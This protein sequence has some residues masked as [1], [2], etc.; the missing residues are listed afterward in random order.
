MCR[1]DHT[2]SCDEAEGV[3]RIDVQSGE[4][5]SCMVHFVLPNGE[6]VS[7]SREGRPILRATQETGGLLRSNGSRPR[8]GGQGRGLTAVDRPYPLA[9]AW[10]R[11]LIHS[12]FPM[13][14]IAY[15]IHHQRVAFLPIQPCVVAQDSIRY[16][17]LISGSALSAETCSS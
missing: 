10:H 5:R 17:I 8:T 12:C 2:G 4:V 6:R 3:L 16:S 9:P 1:L 7:R 13:V 11:R 14:G 15:L